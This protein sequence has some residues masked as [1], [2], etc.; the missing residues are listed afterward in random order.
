MRSC[1]SKAYRHAQA[2]LRR[3]SFEA[4]T[5]EERELLAQGACSCESC[6]LRSS[7]AVA[8]AGLRAFTITPAI[9]KRLAEIAMP[10]PGGPR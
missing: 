2:A 7:L 6:E 9:G 1:Y 10:R 8:D 3:T 4:L 5:D